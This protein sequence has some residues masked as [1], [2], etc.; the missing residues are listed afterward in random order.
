MV[1]GKKYNRNRR[2]PED[3]CQV[4]MGLHNIKLR[5]IQRRGLAIRRFLVH[6]YKLIQTGGISG[7]IDK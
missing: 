2:S 3:S 6:G 1:I 5:N 4:Q 7:S